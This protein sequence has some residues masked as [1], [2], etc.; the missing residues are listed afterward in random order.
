[1]KRTLTANMKQAFSGAAFLLSVLGTAVVLTMGVFQELYG[2][3]HSLSSGLLQNGW[4]HS[5]LQTAC[6]SDVLLLTLP[7]LCALPF[8][9]SYLDDLK[10]G[11]IKEYLPR[12]RIFQ[13]I[14][15]K[16]I[17]CACSG[18]LALL[19]GAMLFCL[20]SAVVFLPLEQALEPGAQA[21]PWLAE[22]LQ[23]CILLFCSGGFWALVGLTS[24]A[25]TGSKY[26]AYASPF[27]FYYVLVILCE[28]YFKALYVFNP[29]EWMNPADWAL[30]IWG[31]VVLLLELSALL[32]V[33]FFWISE[34]RLR[35]L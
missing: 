1:M 19:L 21:Q 16:L 14:W 7:V 24:S 9:A 29:K 4:H 28:R 17:V 15:A 12:T 5:L 3:V 6:T 32:S 35:Q 18:A 11:F 8:T 25:A 34:R 22:L 31:V 10:S 33:L 27:I 20:V 13:Y 2:A 26:M 30:G 23:C